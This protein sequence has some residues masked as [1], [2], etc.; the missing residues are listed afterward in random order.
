MG[1]A[2]RIGD[3][4]GGA[5]AA[6]R[7]AAGNGRRVRAELGRSL[8]S[9]GTRGEDD[10]GDPRREMGVGSVRPILADVGNPH[11]VRIFP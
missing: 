7:T 5:A 2:A 8:L 1:E 6:A 11:L 3:A 4:G 10:D 9:S